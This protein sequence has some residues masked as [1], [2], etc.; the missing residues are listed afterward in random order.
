MSKRKQMPLRKYH[1]RL[2]AVRLNEQAKLDRDV[3]LTRKAEQDP[4]LSPAQRLD[5]LKRLQAWPR[6][7]LGLYRAELEIAQAKKRENGP[8]DYGNEKPSDTAC[9]IV[10][11]T[12]LLGPDRIHDLCAEGRDQE[13]EGWPPKPMNSAAYFVREILRGPITKTIAGK[14]APQIR[15]GTIFASK[16]HPGKSTRA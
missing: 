13:S 3:E 12:V 4:N 14:P 7:V 9:R 1:A 8:Q 2:D 11:E 15:G 10:G 5:I 16:R 6:I